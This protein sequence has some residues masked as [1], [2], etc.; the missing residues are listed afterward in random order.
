MKDTPA[1]E[2]AVV[3]FALHCPNQAIMPRF[4]S[5]AFFILFVC[6]FPARLFIHVLSYLHLLS[7]KPFLSW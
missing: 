1:C 5:V 7:R 4:Q 3:C 6:L 2:K